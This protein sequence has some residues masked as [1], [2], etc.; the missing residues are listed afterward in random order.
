MEARQACAE[1]RIEG[2]REIYD[3]VYS[4]GIS[5]NS[6][7]PLW[8]MLKMMGEEEQALEVLRQFENPQV[9]FLMANWLSYRQFDPTPF[10]ALMA[11]LARENVDRPPPRPLPYACTPK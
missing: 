9:P 3:T 4:G 11:V 7:N 8:L 6:G 1:D 10:P 5:V 2:V